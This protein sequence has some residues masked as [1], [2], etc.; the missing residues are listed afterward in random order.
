LP[1]TVLDAE[2]GVIS[3]MGA[4]FRFKTRIGHDISLSDLREQ[5]D[6]VVVAVGRAYLPDT[7]N[8][9]A[10]SPSRAAAPAAG[11]A[12]AADAAGPVTIPIDNRT[13]QTAIAG[14]FCGGDAAKSTNRMSVRA[15]ADGKAIAE[16]IDQ[17]LRLGP[18]GVVG[19]AKLYTTRVGKVKEG[20][21]A[22]FMAAA[23]ASRAG[24]AVPADGLSAEQAVGESLRCLHCDCAKADNCRLRDFSAMCD[25]RPSHFKAVRRT[26]E[27]Y[28]H[29]EIVYE[30][31]KCIACGLCIRVAER[32]GEPVGLTFTGRSFGVRMAVPLGKSLSEGLQKCAD[33]C[34]R[35]CP[36]GAL[37]KR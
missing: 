13:Y 29:G 33:E 27:Y 9:V 17:Y 11:A 2:I 31:G 36:T 15:V 14:V 16:S 19:Q 18:A 24:R 6:A 3:R 23:S 8:G 4:Q 30:P 26:F 12:P 21:I 7:L 5:F 28:R 1:H 34:V 22:L 32:S 20:E 35:V 37:G 25:A 10:I